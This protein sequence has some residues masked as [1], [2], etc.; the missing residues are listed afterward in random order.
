MYLANKTL[1]LILILPFL[2]YSQIQEG[3]VSYE[4][5]N[6]VK[7][8]LT[9][10]YKPSITLGDQVT[11]RLSGKV[12]LRPYE[13]EKK[14]GGFLGIGAKR[15]KERHNNEL[16]AGNF[17]TVVALTDTKYSTSEGIE[18]RIIFDNSQ[19][20]PDS[21]EY[22]EI[23]KE[24]FISAFIAESGKNPYL[25]W[26]QLKLSVEIETIGRIEYLIKL[27]EKEKL[28][29]FSAIQP[30]L[31]M[32]NVVRQHPNEL[33]KE[34]VAYYKEKQPGILA[35]IKQDLYEYLLI[36]SPAN[37]SI[38]SELALTYSE[39][40]QFK[41]A[42]AEAKKVISELQNKNEQDLQDIDKAAFATS[43]L[44]LADVVVNEKMS[45]QTK[46]QLLGARYYGISANYFKA[47]GNNTDYIKTLLKQVKCLQSVSTIEALSEAA[48]ILENYLK[49]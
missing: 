37:L 20:L 48:D 16:N 28:Q 18:R 34:L 14:K 17:K 7:V 32:G 39:S 11:V 23:K 38:R 33:A 42:N 49:P 31:E 10:A 19:L 6:P 2:S 4:A 1:F 36:K 45:T 35:K 5:S 8:I 41:T 12:N 40:W 43:Y 3:I 30:F 15:Y 47:I 13:V 29:T 25:G 27:L 9:G 26:S 46:S 24:F 21:D 22:K 44:V